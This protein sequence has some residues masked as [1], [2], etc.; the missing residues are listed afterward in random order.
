[1]ANIVS[2]LFGALLASAIAIAAVAAGSAIAAG[3][4]KLWPGLA[5]H[6]RGVLKWE[7][8]SPG[9]EAPWYE[10]ILSHHDLS[11]P[12]AWS[13]AGK[14]LVRVERRRAPR[15][16]AQHVSRAPIAAMR[17]AE[18]D[19]PDKIRFL[20]EARIC[21]GCGKPRKAFSTSSHLCLRCHGAAPIDESEGA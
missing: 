15:D 3:V 5:V 19:A 10:P 13:R 12:D 20:H 21:A 4:L 8:Y 16:P 18:Q 11:T 7:N 2:Y 14:K 6:V 9:V 1:M 17:A